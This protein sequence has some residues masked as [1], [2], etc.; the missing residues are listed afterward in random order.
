M[1][2]SLAF[3]AEYQALVRGRGFTLLDDWTSIP[4]TG[5]DRQAFLNNFCTNDV[6][7]LVPG[8]SCEVFVTNVKGHV[9]GHGVIDCRDHSLVF[10]GTS[11]QGSTLMQHLDRYI[12]REDI[13]LE[14][15]TSRV[16]YL[17]LAGITAEEAKRL[18]PHFIAWNL[19]G[20]DGAGLLEVPIEQLDQVIAQLE[21]A[22]AIAA[23][24][25]AWTT[26]R[27][28]A[29][30]PLFGADFN[31]DNLPQEID[32]DQQ[33]ISFT[34]GCYLGQETVARIDALGHV[35]QKLVGLRFLSDQ[36]PP[37]GTPI[38][39]GDK[40]VGQVTSAVFSPRLQA[41]L[42]IAIVRRTAV[43]SGTEL[44]SEFGKCVVA[45]LPVE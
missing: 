34:K 33:A 9:L 1:N 38:T 37:H 24:G 39:Q 8:Q 21:N 29:G 2:T 23:S 12:L 41:P 18:S 13:T 7:R 16:R 26:A 31:I 43:V 6:K 14:D 15:T 45:N 10:I 42:A 27:V 36:V 28:E 44:N 17:Q 5:K 22:G 40:T 32:R 25:N 30:V 11:G 35:N 3:D 20:R 4:L 19:I